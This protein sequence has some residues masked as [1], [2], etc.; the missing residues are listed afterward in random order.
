METSNA[1]QSR[2]ARSVSSTWQAV[3]TAELVEDLRCRPRAATRDIFQ[4]LADPLGGVSLGGDVEEALVGPGVLHH[5]LGL[6]IDRE[7]HRAPR[8]LKVLDRFRRFATEI[9]HISKG[10]G[11]WPIECA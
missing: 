2:A 1:L 4:A 11:I 6:S 9:R 7:Q 8:G 3:L 10:R 5:D